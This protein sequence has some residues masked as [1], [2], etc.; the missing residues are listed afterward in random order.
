MAVLPGK[1]RGVTR[2]Q[3]SVYFRE[4]WG[5]DVETG[6]FTG[7]TEDMLDAATAPGERC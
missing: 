7:Q 3:L 6:D 4:L 5:R 2:I 1:D